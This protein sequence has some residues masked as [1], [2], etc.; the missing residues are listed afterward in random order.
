MRFI[1]ALIVVGFIFF[2]FLDVIQGNG[3]ISTK[4]GCQTHLDEDPTWAAARW[5]GLGIGFC[6][7]A[8]PE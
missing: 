2:A 8:T 7:A 3:I 4:A 6:V 5:T 1:V